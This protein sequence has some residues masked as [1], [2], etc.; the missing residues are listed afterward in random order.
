[1]NLR[2]SPY[3]RGIPAPYEETRAF[4]EGMAA[5]CRS[6]KWGYVDKNGEIAIPCRYDAAFSFRYGAACVVTEG[7]AS[8]IDRQGHTLLATSYGEL[9]R[10]A[11]GWMIAKDRTVWRVGCLNPAGELAIPCKYSYVEFGD[12][13]LAKVHTGKLFQQ[14][15]ARF[16]FVN[17]AGE[18]VIPLIYTDARVFCGGCAEVSTEGWRYGGG[19]WGLLDETGAYIFEPQFAQLDQLDGL[20]R[21]AL[22]KEAVGVMNLAGENILPPEYEDIFLFTGGVIGAQKGE[23]WGLYH[24]DGSELMPFRYDYLYARWNDLD[25]IG[26]AMGDKEGYVDRYGNIIIPFVYD[27]V[28]PFHRGFAKVKQRRKM[29]VIDAQG[30]QIVPCICDDI[31]HVHGSLAVVAQG[32]EIVILDGGEPVL[33]PLPKA[34]C[35]PFRDDRAWLQYG[36]LWYVLGKPENERWRRQA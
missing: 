19:K 20:V 21:F 11:D 3:I 25:R 8:L 17:R 6:G 13:A 2:S 1:M 30:N 24:P 5:V 22:S 4:R 15:S 26:A 35:Y 14:G 18:E 9:E 31:W 10:Q 29:G 7:R 28:Y 32:G 23:R 36:D 34:R 16:G 12:G 27:D 33:P